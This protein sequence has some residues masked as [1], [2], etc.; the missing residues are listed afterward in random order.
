MSGTD[1]ESDDRWTLPGQAISTRDYSME[2]GVHETETHEM[3][4]TQE[5]GIIQ[6]GN[7]RAS[8]DG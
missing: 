3:R 7:R 4:G 8:W 5:T 1:E 2:P 6:V